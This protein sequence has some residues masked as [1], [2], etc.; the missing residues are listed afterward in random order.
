M[1]IFPDVALPLTTVLT[2]YPQAQP[3]EVLN[4]VTMPVEQAIADI[5]GLEHMTSTSTEG[6]SVV[7][8]QFEYGTHMD[9]V[10]K[11]IAQ[12]LNSVD[13][14]AEVRNL[15]AM[16]AQIEEN[17]RLLPIDLNMMPVV[18]LS[19]YGDIPTPELRQIALTQVLPEL[20]GIDGVYD[21][22]VQGGTSDKILVNLSLEKMI[23]AEV[24]MAQISGA[25][26][27]Q[28]YSLVNDIATAVLRTD[29]LQ[30]GDI[31]TVSLGPAPGTAISR[32][33]GK[34]SINISVTKEAGANTVTTVNSLLDKVAEI[35]TNLPQGLEF[36]TVL[37]QSEYI[38]D[39]ISGLT[40]SALIGGALSI[41]IVFLFLMAFRASLITA[42]SIPLSLLI[43]F[44]VMRFTGLT[45]N[46]LTLSAMVI[47]VGRVIDNSIVLLEVIY[48][49][50]QQGEGFIDAVTNGTKEVVI[51]ITSATV[52]TVVIFVPLAFVGGMVGNLFL[53]FA[54]T[55]TYA[56]IAS[57]LVALTIIPALSG[58]LTAKRTQKEIRI[59]WYLKGYTAA[60]RW[61]LSHRLVTVVI[62]VILFLGSF[63]L[64]PI[65]GTSFMPEMNIKQLSIDIKMPKTADFTAV[66]ETTIKVEDILEDS[67]DVLTYS[68]TVGVP[69]YASGGFAALANAGGGSNESNIIVSLVPDADVTTTA[70]KFSHRLD[71]ITQI[72]TI[73]VSP[74]QAMAAPGAPG[75]E[76]SVRGNSYEDV[77]LAGS[78]LLSALESAE[79][80]SLSSLTDLKLTIATPQPKLII[81]PDLTKIMAMGLSVQQMQQLQQEFYLLLR[82]GVIAEAN[83]EGTPYEIFIEGIVKDTTSIDL[84]KKLPVGASPS[85]VLGDIANIEAGYLLT[86]IRRV[87]QKT[88]AT[89]T[90]TFTQ[91]NV[92]IVN[93][94]VQSE[95]DSLTLVEGVEISMGGVAEDM[96][97]SFQ[98]MF[99][100]MGIAVLLALVV[101]VV[102][103][104]SFRNPL[105]VM[106]SLPLASIG[107]FVGLLVTGHTLGIAGLMGILMLIGIVLTNAVVLIDVIEQRRKAG[108]SPYD[109]LILGG[110]TRLRPILMTALTTMIAMLPLAFDTGGG[111]LMAAELATVVIGG[112]FSSTILTLLVV[113]VIYAL[114][115]RFVDNRAR[116]D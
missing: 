17:P 53:P 41:V 26:A 34:P 65:I 49:H 2:V 73:R 37:N 72:G 14:P 54:L 28:E 27:A 84:V 47:A 82:G 112:L 5:K 43:G 8:I 38:E 99:K 71:G 100:A 85:V 108:M 3:E 103:F 25:L 70:E 7:F 51:P 92:G 80:K 81:E 1:V 116:R 10:N 11:I 66:N 86:S 89:I 32:T 67:P 62:A 55:I 4:D 57:L 35:E 91:E 105:I 46:I 30:L 104:R 96:A 75:V 77:T 109:A 115:H 9:E 110:Q 33:N 79:R 113:P 101:L 95:I 31:A 68:T 15:P 56:L 39:S 93:R 106:V 16:V 83:L 64:L 107:A 21:A 90:A 23:Q 61:C 102:T 114:T 58:F 76:I 63:L 111:V 48:R 69:D 6:S 45:I 52:A 22:A 36:I 78:Q 97:E 98:N 12:K 20:K 44:L 60:L 59:S 88:A 74:M 50:I 29:G 40:K 18:T 87:D 19:L 13:L 94:A 42:V 24:S